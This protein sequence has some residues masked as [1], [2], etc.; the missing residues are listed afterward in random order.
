MKKDYGFCATNRQYVYRLGLWGFAKYGQSHN[1][2]SDSGNWDDDDDEDNDEVAETNTSSSFRATCADDDEEG[3]FADTTPPEDPPALNLSVCDESRLQQKLAADLLYIVGDYATASDLYLQ[4]SLSQSFKGDA[5]QAHRL[6]LINY[7]NT[8]RGNHHIT[9][10]KAMIQKQINALDGPSTRRF[11]KLLKAVVVS[12]LSGG[13]PEALDQELKELNEIMLEVEDSFVDDNDD[14][15]MLS[16]SHQLID[17]NALVLLCRAEKQ[18]TSREGSHATGFNNAPGM[19]DKYVE[20]QLRWTFQG[21]RCNPVAMHK[22]LEWCHVPRAQ[23]Q[24]QG[25][26]SIDSFMPLWAIYANEACNSRQV[27]PPWYDRCETEMGIS[28]TALL[29]TLCRYDSTGRLPAPGSLDIHQFIKR[30]LD[31][32]VTADSPSEGMPW[33]LCDIRQLVSQTL[34]VPLPGSDAVD[35]EPI[36]LFFSSQE[37]QHSMEKE[38]AEDMSRSEYSFIDVGAG[39]YDFNFGLGGMPENTIELC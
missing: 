6:N 19:R 20:Q 33:R 37:N 2:S 23:V 18:L 13:D 17:M 39:E 8:A 27:Q 22:C 14:H 29:Y 4:Y 10:A 30:Y 38:D 35:G 3:L 11:F 25:Y 9:T 15:K 24:V 5:S 32:F 21:S 1:V 34:Y 28:P 36:S 7:A 12:R 16:R 26:S 31:L